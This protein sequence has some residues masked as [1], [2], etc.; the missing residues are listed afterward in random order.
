[1]TDA[2]KY[3]FYFPAWTAC[4]AANNWRVSKKAVVL[5]E[6]RLT[7]EG[8]KV[9]TFA[10]QRAAARDGVTPG[11]PQPVT[12]DDLRHGAHWLALGKDK[13]SENL[14][15]A[16][17]DRVV[18]LFRLL[19]DPDDL[20]A[21][22]KWDAFERGEDPGE[23]KRLDWSIR[24]AAPEAYARTVS[25]GLFGSRSWELLTVAQ[26]R[27]LAMTLNERRKAKSLRTATTGEKQYSA[28]TAPF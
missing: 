4:V 7:E 26:K 17:V 23:V 9:L 12:L 28:A 15:N 21:R 3:K 6:S 13:S 24:N 1:M 5:D 11:R 2:Q 14:T 27:R 18:T 20:D 8:R 22:M 19:Q 16:D 10:R 25:A